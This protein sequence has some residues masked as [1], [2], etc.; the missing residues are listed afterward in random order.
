LTDEE[1]GVTEGMN[2][3]SEENKR[4]EYIGEIHKIGNFFFEVQING[5]NYI[6]LMENAY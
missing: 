3:L 2:P 4:Y 1:A 6:C 5:G